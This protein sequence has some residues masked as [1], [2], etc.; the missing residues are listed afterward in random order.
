MTQSNPSEP[1]SSG[2][3]M[4][5]DT[6]G[7][8]AVPLDRYWGAQ[9]QRALANF[10]IGAERMPRSL[11]H[12]IALIKKAAAQTNHTLGV[13][14]DAEARLIEAAA[15]DVLSGGLDDHFPLLVWQSGSGTQTNMNVNEVIANRAN[16]L[17]GTG[18][19]SYE[20]VHPN[21]HVNRSQ[22]S[23]DVVPTAIHLAVR[24]DLEDSL[25]PSLQELVEELEAK[26]EEIGPVVKTGRTHLQDA[27]PITL[28]QEI[29]A[30]AAQLEAARNSLERVLEPLAELPLGGTAVGT[31]INTP[32]GY[33][34]LVVERL[35][36]LSGRAWFPAEN[37]F[38]AIAAHDALVGAS[39]GLRQLASALAK[40]ASD[41]RLLS[42][43]PRTG[44][45]ELTI[46]A[47]EPG[48]SIM[49]GKVNPT[50]CE[51]VLMVCARVYGNDS[52]VTHAAGQGILQL[53]V[54]R[55]VLAHAL[56]QSI[57]L[58]AGAC[59]SF[60]ER[61]VAGMQPNRAVIDANLSR[62]LML[63][64]ALTPK[65]GYSRSAE[66]ARVAHERGISL[67]EAALADGVMTAEEFDALV[68]PERMVG[69]SF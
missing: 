33:T 46:P 61:C 3:R 6:L 32:T 67:R 64:T 22:S 57:S 2:T 28:G 9:T 8:V 31:G 65:L 4:E 62:S 37:R 25:L 34:D 1:A 11:I 21:D 60:A 59:R 54:A 47:N 41:V 26:A 30:W 15:D 66:L 36:E 53:H 20:P 23:N 10:P 68:R 51:A 16:D 19:G 63:V 12:A 45:G 38:A 29:G 43:G 35:S 44:I 52:V 49:P 50:Q 24:A 40:V 58:L 55:P 7:E 27:T 17:A 14:G 13:L 48:S 18:R 42:S 5:R 56:L 69:E 39:G